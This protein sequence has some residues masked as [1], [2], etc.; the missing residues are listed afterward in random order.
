M[1]RIQAEIL[2]EPPDL[3]ETLNDSKTS[4]TDAALFAY[5]SNATRIL[6]IAE[7]RPGQCPFA[8]EGQP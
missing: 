2:H 7:S 5:S 6:M 8:G 1:A 3:P 4:G